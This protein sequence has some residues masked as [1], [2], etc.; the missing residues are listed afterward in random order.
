MDQGFISV[1]QQLI[2]EQGKETLLTPAKCKPLLADYAKGD[3][4]KESHLLL[5]AIEAGASKA[6]AAAEE[7][8]ICKKQQ[9]RILQEERFLAEE[10]ATDI[11]DT[12]ALVLRG[13]QKSEA[14][15]VC[16]NCGK[17]LELEKGWNFC[18]FCS[19]P[20]KTG[21][22]SS[23][24]ISSNSGSG[25]VNSPIAA[26]T[27]L[28]LFGHSINVETVAYS[29]DG[30]YLASGSWDKT[31]KIWDA[32]S[33]REIR[34]LE[35]HTSTV[36]SVAYSPDGKYLAS[37]SWDKTIR[38]WD[39]VSG[40]NIRTLYEHSGTVCSVAYS[41]D[42]KYLAS[43]SG[44]NTIRIWDIAD[45]FKIVYASGINIRINMRT[46]QGHFGYVNSVAYSPDG[47][48]LASGS[49][50]NTIRIWDTVSGKII[51][52]L[53]GHTFN[54]NS[55]IYSPDGKNLA[56]G[57][58]DKTIKIWDAASGRNI[59]TLEGHTSNVNSVAYSPDGKYLASGSKDTT[60]EIWDAASG[61][62]IRILEEHSLDV[63]SV[64]YSPDGKYLASGSYD[65][66][67]RIRDTA[68]WI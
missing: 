51:Q 34:T 36:C 37:G 45:F 64:A 65:N 40:K 59:Q 41:P 32:V 21:H 4:K 24:A 15:P 13:E 29:P 63:H 1:L 3:Y 19:T 54:V 44:D 5:Q 11:V 39:M 18:P 48:Y 38:I 46:L 10:A 50:D 60:I 9:V 28:W 17:E 14:S 58:W 66:I 57:S 52:T 25:E 26:K 23:S 35:G 43:G 16:S 8:E 22:E 61:K 12:L 30:K 62:S 33:G 7:L 56:S 31:I 27:E 49:Y 6:I 2:A 47:K 42:G 53:K 55:V 67:I 68:S 20:V